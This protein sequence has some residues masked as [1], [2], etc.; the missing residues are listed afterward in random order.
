MSPKVTVP[1]FSTGLKD[2]NFGARL[3]K[4]GLYWGEAS[5]LIREA[6]ISG[7]LWMGDMMEAVSRL[8]RYFSCINY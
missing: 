3:G 6:C 1:D 5:H 8:L 2:C 4:N 7:A